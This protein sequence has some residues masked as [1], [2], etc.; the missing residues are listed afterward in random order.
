MLS[1]CFY[2]LKMNPLYSFS[3]LGCMTYISQRCIKFDICNKK[4][5]KIELNVLQFIFLESY[6]KKHHQNYK[7]LKTKPKKYLIIL[8]YHVDGKFT[9]FLFRAL[10]HS[11][12]VHSSCS[13][14]PGYFISTCPFFIIFLS[15]NCIKRICLHVYTASFFNKKTKP[16]FLPL[17]R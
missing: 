6:L 15:H 5:N 16:S 2:F 9:N 7:E 14:Y 10:N 17:L 11:F 1:S 4:E 3:G 8:A 12:C 13:W